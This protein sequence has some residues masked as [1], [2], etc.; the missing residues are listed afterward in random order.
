MWL[1]FQI[2]TAETKTVAENSTYL[3]WVAK[4]C[5]LFWSLPKRLNR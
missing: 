4:Q 1:I 2:L 5:I 3:G